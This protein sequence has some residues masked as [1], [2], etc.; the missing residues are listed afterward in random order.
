MKNTIKSLLHSTFDSIKLGA[1]Y[2][3]FFFSG[4]AVIVGFL[5]A[6][7]QLI[8]NFGLL[9]GAIVFVVLFLLFSLFAGSIK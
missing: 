3:A 4:L 2:A 8:V 1:P 6:S 7:L 9:G 5:I